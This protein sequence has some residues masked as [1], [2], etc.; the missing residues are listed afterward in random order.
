MKLKLCSAPGC[1]NTAML[2]KNY[3]NKHIALQTQRDNRKIFTQRTKSRQW[4]NL[5]NTQR[6]RKESKEFLAGHPFC[7]V[8]GK[9]SKI[10]DHIQPHRGNLELFYDQTNWQ[11]MC[12]S[13]HTRKT[14][15]EN[16]NFNR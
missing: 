7:Y 6:W 4:H 10:V 9:P 1:M 5:Y 12:W 3:C 15:K 13:C 14:F 8:C 2:G 11:P 16:N